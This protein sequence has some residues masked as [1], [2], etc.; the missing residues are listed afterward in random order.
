MQIL[1]AEST[2]SLVDLFGALFAELVSSATKNRRQ[3][4]K[5]NAVIH[6]TPLLCLTFSFCKLRENK[7]VTFSVRMCSS[8][9]KKFIEKELDALEGEH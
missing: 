2:A 6:R 3:R 4:S 9:E 8:L 7:F 5:S 1:D